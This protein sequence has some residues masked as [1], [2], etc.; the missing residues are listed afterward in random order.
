MWQPLYAITVAKMV[1][2]RHKYRTTFCVLRGDEPSTFP[3][4]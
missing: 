3:P 2:N 4:T 1:T